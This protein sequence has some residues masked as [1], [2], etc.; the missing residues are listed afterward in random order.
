MSGDVHLTR[1]QNVE[2]GRIEEFVRDLAL[3]ERPAEADV[4]F[5]KKPRCEARAAGRGAAFR[6]QRGD[7]GIRAVQ[8]QGGQEDREQVQ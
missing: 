8:H 4:T 6:A 1:V 2:N 7:E 3:A 5:A